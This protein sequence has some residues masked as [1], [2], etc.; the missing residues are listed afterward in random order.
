MSVDRD[1]MIAKDITY[2]IIGAFF[3]VFHIMGSGF[4]ESVYI[5]ALVEEL[6]ARGHKVAREVGVRIFYKGKAIAWQRVD[7][8]V[9]DRVLVEVKAMPVLPASAARQVENYLRATR[10][11]V[12]LLLHFGAEPKPHRFYCPNDL[13]EIEL[14]K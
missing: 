14:T 8:I 3:E 5:A 13:K 2:S 1:A 12:G 9:D 4:L 6:Q 11:E 10:L 7:L